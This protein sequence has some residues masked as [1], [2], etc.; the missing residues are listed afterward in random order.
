VIDTMSRDTKL[1][2]IS[3]M[4]DKMSIKMDSLRKADSIRTAK[5][6]KK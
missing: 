3:F 4:L 6:R 5:K 2:R 1:E